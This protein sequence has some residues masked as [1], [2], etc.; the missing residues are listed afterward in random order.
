M[1]HIQNNIVNQDSII[2]AKNE[3]F[4]IIALADGVSSCE[5]SK[6]GAD[7]ACKVVTDIMLSCAEMFFEFS[8][9]KTAYLIAN[10][11]KTALKQEAKKVNASIE[12][13]SSTLCFAC[14]DKKTK[15]VMTFQVG[16]SNLF[17][18]YANGCRIS[19]DGYDESAFTTSK[20]VDEK[21]IIKIF[22]AEEL[23]GIMLCSDGAWR[24]LFENN[25]LSKR[26]SESL[27]FSNYN[28][29]NKYFDKSSNID[30]CSYI[31]MNLNNY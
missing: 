16:D 20:D 7:I 25:I 28:E 15:K 31:L 6:K 1:Y 17:L 21:V 13:F 2:S 24:I 14:Y 19:S 11:V 10:E 8:C 5:N 26:V 29:L 30:D 27:K 18:L 12:S 22:N 3:R 23:Q 4:E 9:K